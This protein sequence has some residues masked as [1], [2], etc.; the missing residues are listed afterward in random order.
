MRAKPETLQKAIQRTQRLI[1]NPPPRVRIVIMRAWSP[2]GT[3][4]EGWEE[5]LADERR[6][7]LVLKSL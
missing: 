5:F 2:T 7:L 4:D 6:R 3:H 1:D